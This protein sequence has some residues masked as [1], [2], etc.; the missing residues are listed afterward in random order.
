MWTLKGKEK[1]GGLSKTT[2][3]ALISKMVHK[4][5]GGM[6]FINVQKLFTWFI[7]YP[8]RQSAIVFKRTRNIHDVRSNPTHIRPKSKIFRGKRERITMTRLHSNLS[9]HTKTDIKMVIFQKI[10]QKI[11]KILSENIS[12]NLSKNLS[13]IFLKNSI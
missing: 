2:S 3:K 13:K 7:D 6:G 8:R 10:S 11:S 9:S 1:E 5:R 4:L 12:K